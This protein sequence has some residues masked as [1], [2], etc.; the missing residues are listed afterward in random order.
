MIALAE[1]VPNLP[2]GIDPTDLLGEGRRIQVLAT[3][4]LSFRRN[5][6]AEPNP[7]PAI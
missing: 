7:T 1:R 6:A 2:A 3:L 4:A 5:C